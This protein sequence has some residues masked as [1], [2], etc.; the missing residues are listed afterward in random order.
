MVFYTTHTYQLTQSDASIIVGGIIVPSAIIGAVLGGFVVKKFDLEIEGCTN[1]IMFNSTVAVAGLLVILF[2]RCEGP[3]SNGI[4]LS[5][6]SIN[7]SS[8]CDSTCNCTTAY[9]PICG[10]DAISYLSPCYA[11]CRTWNDKGYFNCSCINATAMHN[12]SLP[13]ANNGACS[14][15]C[16]NKKIIFLVTLFIL[17]LSEASCLTP[18][19]ILLLKLV[20]KPL[21]PFSLGIARMAA[22]CIGKSNSKKYIFIRSS[23]D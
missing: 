8:V 1:F 16:E 21:A 12:Q 20:S 9:S 13:L 18:L 23:S 11:G 10:V 17:S 19:T 22:I 5:T 3:V 7:T 6:K 15:G 2:I 4:D 14:R